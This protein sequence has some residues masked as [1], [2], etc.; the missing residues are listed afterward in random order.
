M[1]NSFTPDFTNCEITDG[2]GNILTWRNNYVPEGTDVVHPKE[3][4]VSSLGKM[5]Q[6][7]KAEKTS[8][9]DSSASFDFQI[10]ETLKVSGNVT[11][12]KVE[13]TLTGE[14]NKI[15][16][17]KSYELENFGI[18]GKIDYKIFGGLKEAR[19]SYSYALTEK[20]AVAYGKG[21]TD[22]IDFFNP[23]EKI[24]DGSMAER[25]LSDCLSDLESAS[26]GDY[27]CDGILIVSIPTPLTLGGV[28]GVTI[29]IRL[30][31]SIEGKIEVTLN[32]RT[33]QGVEYKQGKGLRVI[34]DK[35]T[36]SN[37]S[38]QAKA[39]LSFMLE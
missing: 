9:S 31:L 21:A 28:A 19:A 35:D 6:D 33:T 13:F 37:M 20:A 23:D 3:Y 22:I 5:N 8:I 26:L 25:V 39:E 10:N 14:V 38:I 15:E 2:A 29:D 24:T 4:S 32:T 18:D 16:V 34:N 17:S 11:S 7:T 36:D 27:D 12:N 30:G 1:Q